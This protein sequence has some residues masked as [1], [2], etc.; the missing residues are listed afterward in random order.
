M[1]IDVKGLG[2]SYGRRDVLRD[3][4]F[5]IPDGMLVNVLGPTAWANP[6]CSA[7]SSA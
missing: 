6:P 7:A 5:S 4:S 3:V 2:F 1:S